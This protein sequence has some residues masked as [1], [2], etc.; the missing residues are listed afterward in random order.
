MYFTKKLLLGH[1]HMCEIP[2]RF[3]YSRGVYNYKKFK[4]LLYH[5]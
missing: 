1:M 5:G 4:I 2:L 3:K